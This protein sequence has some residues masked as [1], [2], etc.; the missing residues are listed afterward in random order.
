MVAEALQLIVCLRF[1]Q[2]RKYYGRQFYY[3]RRKFAPVVTLMRSQPPVVL[4]AENLQSESN[5]HLR[6]AEVPISL[7]MIRVLLCS[8]HRRQL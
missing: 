3:E 6:Y 2:H 8:L 5:D 7:F 4:L 1:G